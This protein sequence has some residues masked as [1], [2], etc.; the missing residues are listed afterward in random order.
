MC[1]STN[2]KCGSYRHTK[3]DITSHVDLIDALNRTLNVDLI[4]TI[5]HLAG[6]L[7]VLYI[8]SGSLQYV[9]T[10]IFFG[11]QTKDSCVNV[12]VSCENCPILF[13]I[14]GIL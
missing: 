9:L 14:F 3:P 13:N 12:V 6:L 5:N 10:S 1:T 2:S 4:D 11:V 8:N 7:I